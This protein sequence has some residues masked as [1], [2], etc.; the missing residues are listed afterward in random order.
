MIRGIYRAL[1]LGGIAM[2]T[3]C[4]S[5]SP[6]TEAPVM[7]EPPQAEEQVYTVRKGDYLSGIVY[8]ELGL[9]GPAIYRKCLEIQAK[10][11]LGSDRDISMV[12][13]GVLVSGQDGFV[14]L[15]YP[16]EELVLD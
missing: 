10:N 13:D 14:D 15:I 4:S 8:G 12:V 2:L 11:N 16:G 7:P 3:S 1:G 9:R 6:K 5:C